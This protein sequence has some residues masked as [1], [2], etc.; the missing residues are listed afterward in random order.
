MGSDTVDMQGTLS[1]CVQYLEN[2]SDQALYTVL[3]EE[4]SYPLQMAG[5]AG[6]SCTTESDQYHSGNTAAAVYSQLVS[7]LM[8]ETTTDQLLVQ[9]SGAFLTKQDLGQDTSQALGAAQSTNPQ[10]GDA[11]DAKAVTSQTTPDTSLHD[12]GHLEFSDTTSISPTIVPWLLQNYEAADGV[13]L[14]CC[15]VYDH[16]LRH[17]KERNLNPVNQSSFGKIVRSVFLGLKTRRLGTRGNTKYHFCGI[18]EIPGSALNNPL[19]DATPAVR[20]QPF[21]EKSYK[22]L[23]SLGSSGIGTQIREKQCAQNTNQS[24]SHNYSFSL[25]QASVPHQLTG[26][27]EAL[28][29]FPDLEFPPGFSLPEDCTSEDVNTFCNIYREHCAALLNAVVNMKFQRTESLW[30]EFWQSQDRSN[31][32]ECE[33]KYL[34]KT[35]LYLLCKCGPV[36]D[37]V[38]RVDYLLYQDLVKVLIPDVL[39]P[40]PR[41]LLQEIRNFASR[42]ESWLTEAMR[43][44]PEEIVR[45]KMLA[46][47]TL[48]KTLRRYTTLNHLA[49]AALAVFQNSSQIDQMLNDLNRVDFHSVHEQVAWVCECEDSVLKRLETDLKRTLHQQDSLDQLA[50]WMKGVVTQVLEP[51]EG[52]QN[53][54]RAAKQFLLK[55][56]FCVSVVIRDLI[57]RSSASFGS[58]HLIRLLFDDYMFFLIEHEVALEKGVTPIAIMAEK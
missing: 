22:F 27:S 30:R 43:D 34:P 28:F 36:Q 20:Q 39:R 54:S 19:G 51:Y 57:L 16:Y 26:K 1:S 38:R 47:S 4:I 41:L 13:C 31:G 3:D 48:A 2:P 18:R 32:D 5:E 12:D 24:A 25:P 21:S 8:K 11:G 45:S 44:C 23:T 33:D 40:I 29:E 35:K 46:V 15:T 53:F 50:A 49:H 55:W 6:T 56:S 52:N 37:F 7:E 58:F 42:L 14:A 9:E 17:C 10:T